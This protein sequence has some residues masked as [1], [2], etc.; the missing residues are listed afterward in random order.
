[1]AYFI[2]KFFECEKTSNQ[3]D[4]YYYGKDDDIEQDL[5]CINIE[6]ESIDTSL[7]CLLT[8]SDCKN[9]IKDLTFIV[10]SFEGGTHE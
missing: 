6:N 2:K 8:I 5:I 9:L 4:F 3:L 7:S 1:M 10:N